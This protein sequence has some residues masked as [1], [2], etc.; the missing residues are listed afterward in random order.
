M[1]N[2]KEKRPDAERN[3]GTS[4][5]Q[6]ATPQTDQAP[7]GKD[8]DVYDPVGMAGK[9]AGILLELGAEAED[10]AGTEEKNGSAKD[11]DGKELPDPRDAQR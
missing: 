11:D 2:P 6:S 9:K 10:E 7:Q 3:D 8:P 1:A 5:E 4:T